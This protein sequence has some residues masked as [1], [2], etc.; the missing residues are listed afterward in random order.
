[1]YA[2]ETHNVYDAT[3]G[4]AFRF[5]LSMYVI[6]ELVLQKLSFKKLLYSVYITIQLLLVKWRICKW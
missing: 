6:T 4:A 2:D 3:V 1:M 5:W